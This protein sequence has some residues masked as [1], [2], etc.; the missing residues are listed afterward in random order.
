MTNTGIPVSSLFHPSPV[1]VKL[2]GEEEITAWNLDLQSAVPPVDHSGPPGVQGDAV[3]SGDAKEM[4]AIRQGR[5]RLTV[6]GDL[7]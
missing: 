2:W 1:Q 6:T 7:L 4:H 5:L 3:R